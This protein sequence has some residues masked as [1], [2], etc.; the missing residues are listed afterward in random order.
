[1]ISTSTKSD[2]MEAT[3]RARGE[4]GEVWLFDPSGKQTEPSEGVRVALVAGRRS[5]QR[6]YV[7]TR[8]P[9]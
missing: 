8:T 2:V 4:L 5:T 1:V 7:S 3:M 6:V 9:S